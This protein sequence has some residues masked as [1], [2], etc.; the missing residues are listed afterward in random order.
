VRARLDEACR[1][2]EL[3]AAPAF[4]AMREGLFVGGDAALDRARD[5]T[6][7]R[8]RRG[9]RRRSFRRHETP[10]IAHLPMRARPGA[11]K[12]IGDIFAG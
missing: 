8:G 1:D 2:L 10:P 12:A 9:D 6:P 7:R 4:V 5:R 11:S 3:C